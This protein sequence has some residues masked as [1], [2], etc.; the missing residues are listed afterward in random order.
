VIISVIP[1]EEGVACPQTEVSAKFML[2]GA[3]REDGEM[4]IAAFSLTL[5]GEDV[6]L[7]T[8]QRGTMDF[9]QSHGEL[10]YESRNPLAR[11]RHEVTVR[12]PDPQTGNRRIYTW[13]FDVKE[14][15]PCP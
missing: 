11:G 7:Q 12:F 2:K 1:E 5:D 8:K 6:T 9:P 10:I 14:S 13:V 3:M 15:R 4:D